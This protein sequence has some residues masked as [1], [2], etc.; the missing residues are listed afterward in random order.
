MVETAVE[1]Q[2][3]STFNRTLRYEFQF[4]R[5]SERASESVSE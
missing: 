1:S 2:F 5:E 3:Y 4:T